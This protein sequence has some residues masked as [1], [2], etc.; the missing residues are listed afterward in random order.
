MRRA[1]RVL[2]LLVVAM[3][4]CGSQMALAA[5][6]TATLG[7]DLRPYAVVLSSNVYK[8]P[9]TSD[10]VNPNFGFAYMQ[11]VQRGSSQ[12]DY[13]TTIPSAGDTRD[14]IAIDGVASPEVPEAIIRTLGTPTAN[15]VKYEGRTQDCYYLVIGIYSSAGGTGGPGGMN[16]WYSEFDTNNDA[17]EHPHFVVT[18]NDRYC[19]DDDRVGI[20]TTSVAHFELQNSQNTPTA[21]FK[22][23]QKPLSSSVAGAVTFLDGGAVHSIT[24]DSQVDVEFIGDIAGI[25][26]IIATATNEDGTETPGSPK[27]GTAEVAVASMTL[28]VGRSEQNIVESD[29]NFVTELTDYEQTETHPRSPL[30]IFGEPNPIFIEVTGLPAGLGILEKC[31]QVSSESDPVGVALSLNEVPGK[32]GTYRNVIAGWTSNKL[33]LGTKSGS[34]RGQVIRIKTTRREVLTFTLNQAGTMPVSKNVM[35]ERGRTGAGYFTYNDIDICPYG[36][37]KST[38]PIAEGFV[39]GFRQ[40]TSVPTS[41]PYWPCAYLGAGD[42]VCRIG[43]YMNPTDSDKA[44]A[45]SIIMWV[46]HG[47]AEQNAGKWDYYCV[48]IN[49]TGM[50]KL[51][52]DDV[53]LGDTLANWAIFHSCRFLNTDGEAE[54][55]PNDGLTVDPDAVN[56]ELKKMCGHGMRL[57]CGWKTRMYMKPGLGAYFAER[58][59]EGDDIADAWI[60]TS[61]VFPR[62]DENKVSIARVFGAEACAND[63]V[64]PI[65][66]SPMAPVILCPRDPVPADSY[67]VLQELATPGNGLTE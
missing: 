30:F 10:W 21:Y 43:D 37:R 64:V 46:G 27:T 48:F 54:D 56:A 60:A 28:Y 65:T 1:S 19:K 11:N 3:T 34:V 12:T 57:V 9:N 47:T 17:Y 35:V 39:A 8:I 53:G 61:M 7:T 6:G 58:L 22:L 55:G 45:A 67:S 16:R 18:V 26:S 33:L 25:A 59:Q 23:S 2:I 66:D 40:A 50:E 51:H 29:D 41:R 49:E 32:P 20:G 63:N 13:C 38:K 44:D 42:A 31:V 36:K 5:D 52:H 15:V 62:E 4:A 14:L 24:H